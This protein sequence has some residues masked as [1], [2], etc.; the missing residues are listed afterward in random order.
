M[1]VHTHHKDGTTSVRDAMGSHPITSSVW[2]FYE[3]DARIA[4][5][6]RDIMF[7]VQVVGE[8]SAWI[9]KISL[10]SEGESNYG[11]EDEAV[12]AI[13]TRFSDLRNAH[14]GAAVAALYA[15]DG[16]W[17]GPHGSPSLVVG[18]PALAKMWSAVPGQVQRTVESVDFPGANIAIVRVA[19]Q[20]PDIGIHKETFVLVKEDSRWNIRV[21]QTVD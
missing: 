11:R 20:Y 2:T 8:G 17:L 19:V 3:I 12:R 21:H 6:A 18:R 7:G 10:T 14:D 5:D 4:S 1:Q 9:D 16:E 13:I 15:G